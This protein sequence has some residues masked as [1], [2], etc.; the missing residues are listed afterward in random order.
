MTLFDSG[1]AD[2][3]QLKPDE[4]DRKPRG[5]RAFDPERMKRREPIKPARRE[6]V[7]QRSDDALSVSDVTAMV[8]GL[9]AD[10]VDTPV[11]VV[12]E[13]SNFNDRGHWYLSL[14][15]DADVLN[16][17][18]W[19]SAAKNVRFTPERGTQ[20]IAIGR[21]DY[22]GPQGKLQ[23]YIDR[24][25]PVGQG[26]LELRFRQLCDELRTLGW[27]DQDAKQPLPTFPQHIAVITSAGGAA[28]Q[29]VIDTA[30]RRWPGCRLSI[31]DVRVQ[32]SGAAE[33]IAAAIRA[34][35]AAGEAMAVDA[36]IVT[37][38]GGSIE[39]LWQ[40]NERVVAE[41]VHE[42]ALPIV[43]AIGHETDITVAE[44]V[45]DRRCATPTQAAAVL[46]PDRRAELERMT[47]LGQRLRIAGRRRAEAARAALRAVAGHAMFRS[48]TAPID[49]RRAD[50]GHL[51]RRLSAANQRAVQRERVNLAE[52]A[53]R[54][55]ALEPRGRIDRARA[56]LTE[57]RRRLHSAMAHLA[58]QKAARLEALNREL[59]AVGPQQVLERGFAVVTDEQG[60]LVRSTD[61]VKPGDRVRA[62]L[63]DGRFDATV[64]GT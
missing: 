9:L 47:Q 26:A 48:P 61:Q 22:Y 13:L 59:N 38:G 23:L 54:L 56:N 31:V 29:D 21:L 53:G 28:V 51:M 44:L 32:G 42:C 1:D 11:R 60:K 64:E 50:L 5:K 49:G 2:R 63:A 57:N 7:E 19:S 15:D 46:V 17:V 35:D 20:V 3:D 6:S 16:C 10:H 4:P 41:A 24:L 37:R 36:I 58:A 40:F 39:D 43:A 14:K 12:G 62:T 8:K 55:A 34:V 18:M 52:R 33:E 45:A 25:E 30:A 27:F